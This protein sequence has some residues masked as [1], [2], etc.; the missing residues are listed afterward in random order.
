[1]NKRTTLAHVVEQGPL[2]RWVE[3]TKK[4]G[5]KQKKK[6]KKTRP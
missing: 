6:K 4:N 3:K 2:L 5:K 1:M